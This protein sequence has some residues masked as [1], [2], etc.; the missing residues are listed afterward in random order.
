[1]GLVSVLEGDIDK[2]FVCVRSYASVASVLLTQLLLWTHGCLIGLS[3]IWS[4]PFTD[5]KYHHALRAKKNESFCLEGWAKSASGMTCYPRLSSKTYGSEQHNSLNNS[6]Q[7][8]KLEKP[9]SFNEISYVLFQFLHI[10]ERGC[11]A[12]ALKWSS[13]FYYS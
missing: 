6:I 7:R 12:K 8:H 4:L 11:I 13:I 10:T 5:I 2:T 3:A 9:I 1:M